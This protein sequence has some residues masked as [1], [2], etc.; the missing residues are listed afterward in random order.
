MK[1]IYTVIMKPRIVLMLLLVLQPVAMPP[2]A[3]ASD[4]PKETN[5]IERCN[6]LNIED[7][8]ST[9]G[10]WPNYVANGSSNSCGSTDSDSSEGES[11]DNNNTAT[12]GLKEFVDKYG[13]SAFNIGKQF[14]IPYEAILSQAILESGYGKSSLTVKGY[15]FFGIKA[16]SSWNGRVITLRTREQRA[17]GSEYFVIAEF[18]AYDNAEDGFKGYGEFITKNPRYKSALNYPGDPFKYI[19]EIRKAGY[20][21]ALDYVTLNHKLIRQIQAYIKE[22]GAFPPSS[23]VTHDVSPPTVGTDPESSMECGDEAD[24]PIQNDPTGAKEIAKGIVNT[25]SYQNPNAEFACLDKLWTRESNWTVNAINDAEGNND[26]NKNKR[27]DLDKGEEIS[28]TEHDAYGIPQSL[29][30]GKMASKGADWRTNPSTQIAWGMEY[31]EGR[32]G[33]P[34]GAWSHSEQKGWY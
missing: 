15:N 20:A 1:Q 26:L 23:E 2:N 3:I 30:G 16:G 11:E 14:G 22:T 13:Q 12:S 5:A 24:S 17:D 8:L 18:R 19:E 6:N 31:I 10:P 32:Y 25:K 27:L 34:C 4:T 7:C 33:T 29:P 21:T 9:L 28:E